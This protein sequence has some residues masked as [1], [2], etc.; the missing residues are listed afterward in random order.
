MM[1]KR[2]DS[3]KKENQKLRTFQAFD[4]AE[5]AE[6]ENLFLDC[7]D[8]TKREHFKSENA[9]PGIVKEE[10]QKNQTGVQLSINGTIQAVNMNNKGRALKSKLINEN[11]CLIQVFQEMF[12]TNKAPLYE[13]DGSEGMS[14]GIRA[15]ETQ[16]AFS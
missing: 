12:G 6:I 14:I 1:Q 13:A 3:I 5:K 9:K 4:Y 10:N 11:Q 8:Q 2:L 15:G 16:T 7:V